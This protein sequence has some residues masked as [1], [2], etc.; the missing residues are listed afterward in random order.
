MSRSK[1]NLAHAAGLRS[2]LIRAAS[3]A[4]LTASSGCCAWP[5]ADAVSGRSISE[6]VPMPKDLVAA[7]PAAGT[8]LEPA[9]CNR[10]CGEVAECHAATVEGSSRVASL[11]VVCRRYE[12]RHCVGYGSGRRPLGF[13][14]AISGQG[15][16]TSGARYARMYLLETA[17]VDAFEQLS[18]WLRAY[19]APERLIRRARRAASD[20]RRHARLMRELALAHGVDPG[21]ACGDST[22]LTPDLETLARDNAAE[23]CVRETWGALVA[24]LEA[25]AATTP[26]VR[27]VMT[28]IARDE[29]RHA[30]LAWAL[31]DWFDS[32]LDP[33]AR[34]RVRHAMR[35]AAR[36]LLSE[37]ER[38]GRVALA[39]LLQELGFPHTRT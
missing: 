31:S 11:V 3:G 4:L 5:V 21:P 25:A 2:A 34:G 36:E 8:K 23:G 7:R 29:T 26:R 20:E 19:E 18:R 38:S 16:D 6:A 12:P 24:M 28:T 27:Q 13:R 30:A 9:A 1:Y 10:V 37:V 15:S 22:E 14:P 35:E 39:L 32:R 33:R 17:S